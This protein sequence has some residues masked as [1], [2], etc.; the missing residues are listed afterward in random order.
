A[1][2]HDRDIGA[3]A[4]EQDRDRTADARVATCD[5]RNLSVELA[6]ALV[7][8]REIAR[9]FLELVFV[10]GF[11]E[12]LGREVNG[13]LALARLH[14]A[15]FLLAGFGPLLLVATIHPALDFALL[16]HGAGGTSLG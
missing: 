14:G 8:Q 10:S 11:V 16:A 1:Q 2:V 7:V 12:V 3:L 13:L 6:A 4:G 9:L 15:G 5:Q